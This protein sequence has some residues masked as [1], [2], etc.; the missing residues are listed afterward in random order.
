MISPYNTECGHL[1]AVCLSQVCRPDFGRLLK[2]EGPLKERLSQIV[3]KTKN[4]SY[5]PQSLFL[6]YFLDL[7][8]VTQH[9]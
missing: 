6:G 8:V 1:E 9:S 2:L 5:I 3:L 7:L 4:S